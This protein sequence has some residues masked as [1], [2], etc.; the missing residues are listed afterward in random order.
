M[1]VIR[2]S[3]RE[4]A[5]YIG[6]MNRRSLFLAPLVALSLA[7]PASAAEEIPLSVLSSYLNGLVTAK[8]RFRQT[9]PDGSI[10]DGTLYLK[11]PGRL[12]F[13]YDPPNPALVISSGGGV[14]IF[15]NKSNEP[16]QQFP[17]KSTPLSVI[18]Q[19]DVDLSNARMI[20]DHSFDG[21]ITSI[22]A[23]DPDRPDI[24]HIELRFSDNPVA[25]REWIITDQSGSQTTVTILS[26]QTG[27]DLPPSL[28]SI[29]NQINENRTGR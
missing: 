25:L 23:Q 7:L 8:A 4:N 13:E 2:L 9:N 19:R 10:S 17:L 6:R 1:T 29:I 3:A 15:D 21:E 20:V 24:G 18:L 12:R 5:P 27:M 26:M 14:A 16:P 11:R 28:F 22:T